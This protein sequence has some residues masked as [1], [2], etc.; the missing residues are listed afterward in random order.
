MIILRIGLIKYTGSIADWIDHRWWRWISSDILAGGICLGSKRQSTA[1][2]IRQVV[3]I[4]RV[5]GGE[6][7]IKEHTRIAIRGGGQDLT[8]LL[9]HIDVDLYCEPF[10]SQSLARGSGYGGLTGRCGWRSFGYGFRPELVV[11]AILVIRVLA[12]TMASMGFRSV[13][14]GHRV[15]IIWYAVVRCLYTTGS[16][17]EMIGNL[18][19]FVWGHRFWPQGDFPDSR[20]AISNT[21]VIAG[22]AVYIGSARMVVWG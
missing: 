3:R 4:N 1:I 7:M 22:R 8:R 21:V 19:Y 6:G 17:A 15:V 5:F 11:S 20:A 13:T 2:G 9:C 16:R 12:V 18:I 14:I 10:P